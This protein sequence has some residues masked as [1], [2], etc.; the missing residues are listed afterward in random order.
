M[1]I[2]LENVCFVISKAREV[3]ADV[4][5]L[6]DEPGQHSGD[7][8]VKE[9]LPED[10]LPVKPE[11]PELEELRLF[12]EGLNEDEQ[13]ELVALAWVGRGTFT[14]DDWD[15][16]VDTAREEHNRNTARYLL[17]LPLLADYLEDGLSEFDLS[18]EDVD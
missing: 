7:D 5:E 10:D 12:I 17:G 11:S 18:C 16:A 6:S 13:I 3:M 14:A 1:D 9:D 4:H 2:A 15:E 8:L